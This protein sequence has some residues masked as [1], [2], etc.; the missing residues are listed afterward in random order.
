[1]TSHLQTDSTR[2]AV[3]FG[4]YWRYVLA[5]VYTVFVSILLL[6]SSSE[7]LIGPPAPPGPPSLRRE[8][9]LTTGHLSVFTLLTFIWWW[10]LLPILSSERALRFSVRFCLVF[11]IVT[12]LAQ[13]FSIHRS[14]SVIDAATNITA[15][16]LTAWAISAYRNRRQ[17][18]PSGGNPVRTAPPLAP[19]E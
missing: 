9:L 17:K 7:P 14:V 13:T 10:A 1:M 4:R 6:Q 12:E 15:I 8:I 19:G 11:G 3:I 2:V 5:L 16:L 18:S